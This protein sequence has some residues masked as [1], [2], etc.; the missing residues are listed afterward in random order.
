MDDV[1]IGGGA[2]AQMGKTAAES[3]DHS[4][5]LET[6]IVSKN[7]NVRAQAYD[8][9]NKLS[10]DATIDSKEGFFQTHVDQFKVYLKDTNPGAL[11]KCLDCLVNF[12]NKIQ[13]KVLLDAQNRII[14]IIIEKMLLTHAKPGIKAKSLESLLLL[15]EVTQNFDD[16]EDTLQTLLK[17]KNVKVLSNAVLALAQLVENYGV[18]KIKIANYAE[19]MLKNA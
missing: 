12:L 16:S 4:G 8:D 13:A 2:G 1:A 5:P 9:L 15:F 14:Q 10:V 3:A 6:R 11:E 7:W 19:V 18:K 17:H